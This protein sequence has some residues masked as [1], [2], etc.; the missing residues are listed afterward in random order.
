MGKSIFWSSLGLSWLLWPTSAKRLLLRRAK[1]VTA[2]ASLIFAFSIANTTA[3]NIESSA[4]LSSDFQSKVYA[5]LLSLDR[6]RR[7]AAVRSI[8]Y[9]GKD[10]LPAYRKILDKARWEQEKRIQKLFDQCYREHEIAARELDFE[11]ERVLKLIHT[12]FQKDSSKIA[13]LRREMK[14]LDS[15]VKRTQRA[16]AKSP[17]DTLDKIDQY[18]EA[19]RDLHFQLLHFDRGS[20]ND[21][22]RPSLSGNQQ[23]DSQ[24][25]K[26]DILDQMTGGSDFL[27]TQRRFTQTLD[28]IEKFSEVSKY[29]DALPR[30]ASSS[31]K[32]FASILNAER[33]ILGLPPL[34]LE[35]RLSAASLLHSSDM[36]THSF[37]AHESPVPGRK[38]PADR[39]RE[40]NFQH[41]WSGENIFMGSTSPQ[42]AY[43]AWFGSD[44]HRFIMHSQGSSDLLGVGISGSHWTMMTGV[45]R[46]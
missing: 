11:R 27:K 28:E 2:F 20:A 44:G 6:E 13:M 1:R 5:S 42:T 45:T 21:S 41:A 30:W 15:L 17:D 36:R 46:N 32:Q 24:V 29:N 16:A 25:E 33:L 35:E 19:M 26:R 39:A 8:H 14:S 38:T 23:I 18:L 9:A 10:A 40:A 12:D 3:N 31:M 7:A 34:A 43:D 4:T 22:W 37:F